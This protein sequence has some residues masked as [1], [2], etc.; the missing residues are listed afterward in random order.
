MQ[1]PNTSLLFDI[2]YPFCST[3]YVNRFVQIVD[4]GEGY[5]GVAGQ[6]SGFMRLRPGIGLNGCIN[7]C[8]M[9]RFPM[10]YGVLMIGKHFID[11]ASGISCC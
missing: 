1:F 4:I 3:I 2:L 9:L 10:S 7:G 11:D 6:M 8:L 5:V